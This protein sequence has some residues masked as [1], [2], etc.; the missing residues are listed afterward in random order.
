[1]M[2]SKNLK[3]R[4]LDSQFIIR[5]LRGEVTSEEREYFDCWLAQSDKNKEE[6]SS[7]SLIWDKTMDAVTP[8]TP[9]P[10]VQWEFIFSGISKNSYETDEIETTE[11]V[12]LSPSFGKN[13]IPVKKADNGEVKEAKSVS[14]PDYYYRVMNR[15]IGLA[16]ILLVAAGLYFLVNHGK[17]EI[18][19][20][21]QVAAERI[22]PRINE[23][24]ADKGER[25][26]LHLADGS[27]VYLNAESKLTFPQYFDGKYRDVEIEGEAYFSVKPDDDQPFRVISGNTTVLVTGTEFNIKNRNNNISVV[28]TKGNIIA[29]AKSV[30]KSYNVTKGEMISYSEK[31]GF[32]KPLHVNVKK[33]L[34]WRDGKFYFEQTPLSEVMAEIGRFYNVKVKFESDSLK[35]KTI[36]GTFSGNSLDKIFSIICLTLDVKINYNGSDVLVF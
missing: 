4:T 7:L 9:D 3:E 2:R 1:M 15:I 23:I 12:L 25:K 24:T 11:G 19:E 36:T 28:V 16:A 32:S 20:P 26:T 22:K 29:Y 30:E 31:R 33:Y 6:F 5:V 35:S 21:L 34:G 17:S 14:Y 18:V 27:L 8:P 10:T 13:I